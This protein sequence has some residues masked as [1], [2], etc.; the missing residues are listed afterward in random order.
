MCID[1]EKTS[2]W[3]KEKI[4]LTKVANTTNYYISASTQ[5]RVYLHLKMTVLSV[6]VCLLLS[7]SNDSYIQ[8][9]LISHFNSW[10]RRMKLL[11]QEE[12][13]PPQR[14]VQNN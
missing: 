3:M 2:V 4:S 11:K 7:D 6:V 5:F 8:V 9:Y 14:S 10:K 13:L 1:G 12:L